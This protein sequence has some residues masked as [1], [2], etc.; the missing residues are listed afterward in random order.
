MADEASA[1]L[2][3][4]CPSRAADAVSASTRIAEND[5][6]TARRPLLS[7]APPASPEA[8]VMAAREAARS[9][10]DARR[11]AR[12]A[13]GFRGLRVARDRDA[14]RLRRRQ[15][16]K[17]RHVRRRGARLRRRHR[18]RPFV[19]RSGKLLDLMMAAIGLDRT[20]SLYRQ[21]RAVAAARQP[22]ADAAGNRDLPALH[23]PP[24]RAGQSGC[25]GLPRRRRRCKRCSASRK[26]SQSSRGRWFA[27]RYRHARDPRAGDIPPR[28]LAA[29]PAAKAV[30]LARFSGAEESAR[31]LAPV[32]T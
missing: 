26:A 19:G 22:H 23:P 12:A 11:V 32:G 31:G 10:Q 3:P 15:S 24:D 16:A 9:A 1:Q 30:C 29:Q 13:R 4:R 25:P 21:C 2:A 17:P 28:I 7:P 6:G 18:G 27:L 5:P 20:H 8:A 14:A